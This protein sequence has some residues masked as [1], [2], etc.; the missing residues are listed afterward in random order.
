MNK[1]L[2]SCSAEHLPGGVHYFSCLQY[3]ISCIHILPRS[4]DALGVEVWKPSNK[5]GLPSKQVIL[6]LVYLR[7]VYM[8]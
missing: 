2:Y 5:I 6:F 4:E 1:F 7:N 3:R 8:I